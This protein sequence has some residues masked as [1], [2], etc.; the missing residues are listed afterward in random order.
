MTSKTVKN[1]KSVLELL[2]SVQPLI[3]PELFFHHGRG[4]FVV[5]HSSFLFLVALSLDLLVVLL[6]LLG[7]ESP[8]EPHQNN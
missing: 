5:D 7:L 1:T 2:R 3:S 4:S 8:A 6:I